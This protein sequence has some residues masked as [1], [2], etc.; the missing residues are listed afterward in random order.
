MP[1]RITGSK[2][3]YFALV[4]LFKRATVVIMPLLLLFALDNNNACNFRVK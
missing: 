3:E 2:F 4:R 1:G